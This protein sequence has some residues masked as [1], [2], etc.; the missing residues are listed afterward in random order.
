MGREGILIAGGGLAGAAAAIAA[1]LEGSPVRLIE[2]AKTS[3]HKVCGEFISPE[4]RQVMEALHLWDE[5]ASLTPC[6][7]RRCIL[8]LGK[9]AKCWTFPERAWGLSRLQLDRLLLSKAATLGAVV[10]RGEAFDSQPGM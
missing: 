8:H 2:R 3:R 1:R 7:I 10:C 9:Y 6:P 5:F 4:T